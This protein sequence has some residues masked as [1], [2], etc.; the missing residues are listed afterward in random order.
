MV[1]MRTDS[2]IYV[3]GHRGLVGSAIVRRLEREG[4]SNLILRTHSELDLEDQRAVADF[5]EREKPDYV[6]L[7]AAKV[8]GIH[9]NNVYRADFIL[10]NLQI[11]NNVI[12]ESW[13]SGV[14]K[15]L[16]LGSSCIYPKEAPQPMREDALLTS[17]LEYTNEP[18]AIAKIAGIKLCESLNLQYGT[19]FLSVMPTN[20]Y[21][22][23][24]NFDLEKS[25]VLPAL[26][27][28]MHLAQLR[29]RERWSELRQNLGVATDA[30]AEVML[31]RFGVSADA[32]EIWGTGRPLREFLH[33]DDM[34]DAC[35]W[36]MQNID[37]ADLSSGMTEV[38]NT[39]INIGSGVDLS[40]ADLA[41]MIREIV[42][43]DGELRFNAAKPDGTMRKLMD[44]SK[45]AALGWTA[46]IGLREGIEG[47]YRQYCT[48]ATKA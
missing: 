26:L 44:V 6:F 33:S 41:L 29:R 17:T 35:V 10:K 1:K 38:R 46:K 15:L 19:N 4:Y 42:G 43:F 18:Y 39:H 12:G 30:E 8:G 2:R 20:L 25:H 14:K 5:F 22:P 34:A 21:G 28:K 45:L 11:Q 36:L 47:V 37:F 48:E 24:D 23:G 13:R 3:A 40:I 31:G 16:F 32:V 7:A 9:A 27:R